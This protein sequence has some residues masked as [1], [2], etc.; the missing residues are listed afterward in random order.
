MKVLFRFLKPYTALFALVVLFVFGESM[1]ELYLPNLMASIVD[2]GV[3]F[4]DTDHIW[5]VGGIM[6]LVAA[7]GTGGA[8]MATFVSARVANAFGRDVRQR[9]FS[10]VTSFSLHEFDEL[11]TSTLITRTTNDVTQVQRVLNVGMRMFISAPLMAIGGI[12][13]AR[14]T[15]VALSKVVI[16][17]IPILGVLIAIIA[18]KSMPLFRALQQKVDTLNRV[19]RERLTG[20]RVVRAFNRTGHE[21]R[22]FTEANRDLTDTGIRVFRLM[23]AM[24]PLM[25][26]MLNLTTVAIMWFGGLRVDAGQ[27]QVGNLMAFIQYIMLIMFSLVMMSMIFVMLPRA[28]VSANRINEVLQV[29]PE[30]VDA[31]EAQPTDASAAA[32][33]AAVATGTVEFRRVTFRYPGAEQPA[34]SDISFTARPGETTA[35][36]GGTGSGKSTLIKL[37]TRFYDVSEGSV[38]VD[39]VDVREL[40]QEALRSKMG[41]VPQRAVLFSG[42]VAENIRYG[43]GDASDEEVRRAAETA[44]ALDFIEALD[45]GFDAVVAQGGANLSGGQRQR[46]TIARALVRK[47]DMYIFDDSF[48]ALDFRTDARLRAALK[49]ETGAASVFIVGQRV[50]SI[51]DADQIIVLDEGRI[52]GIGTH[53]ELLK[54]SDVYAEIVASQLDGE[55]V[56]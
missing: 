25:M 6:L 21:Q 40:T 29:E 42:T 53:E 26:L 18:S 9:I 54:T 46:L 27:M 36:I 51:M 3:V 30:I 41:L 52:A 47:P 39:G 17:V 4:G 56:A 44:Q 49:S 34:L 5:R 19:V 15:D 43:K 23:A 33:Q 8:V 45:D 55:A 11:G 12:V 20:V 22:R 2:E 35:I 24:M 16:V 28:V 1:A 13:M 7:L 14:A 37:M 32:S 48:S 10:K 50:S 31:P 38:L